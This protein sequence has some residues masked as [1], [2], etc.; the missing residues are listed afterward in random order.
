M[1]I[2]QIPS[3]LETAHKAGISVFLKGAPGTAKT[4]AVRQ[5]ANKTKL[6]LVHIHAPLTDALDIRGLPVVD[7]GEAKFQPLNI[8]PGEKDAPVV[9]LIDELPQCV[10]A[11]QNAYSQLLI[12]MQLGDVKLPKGSFVVATGNRREDRAATSNIPSHIVNRV[13]HVTVDTYAEDFLDWAIENKIDPMVIAF[14]RF[15][16]SCL[17]TFDAKNSQEPYASYR[18]WEMASNFIKQVKD[19]TI[20]F[21]A[22]SGLVGEGPTTEFMAYK[23]L[24]LELPDPKQVLANPELAMI[25]NDPATLYALTT[26][27][28]TIVAPD[29]ADNLIALANRLPVEYAVLMIKTGH[30]LCPEIRKA[31]AFQQ[32]AMSNKDVI[33]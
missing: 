32:W 8:W 23:R 31:K 4:A 33:L 3:L 24:Y 19:D 9:V 29:T 28:A 22:L 12:D 11:I 25:P 27:I 1:K 16:P 2:S 14:G 6:R 20:M 15:R 10:P 30:K 26:A 5:Y 18:T 13:L 21:E 17:H 7:N